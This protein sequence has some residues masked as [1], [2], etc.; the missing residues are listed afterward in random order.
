[1]NLLERFSFLAL[2]MG[3]LLLSARAHPTRL[4]NGG[5]TTTRG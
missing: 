5:V 3:A 2:L 1:M 4:H